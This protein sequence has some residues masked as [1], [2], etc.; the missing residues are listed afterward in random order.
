MVFFHQSESRNC[1]KSVEF[2]MYS[3]NVFIYEPAVFSLFKHQSIQEIKFS[4]GWFCFWFIFSWQKESKFLFSQVRLPP[5][6]TSVA[7][8]FS[9]GMEVEVYSR[10]NDREACGW[11]C[12]DIKVRLNTIIIVFY[13]HHIIG[14]VNKL[15]A[16]VIILD[17]DDQR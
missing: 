6:D 8:I 3:G 15:L 10:S 12:A 11:W 2:I 7:P 16:F 1:D 5:E 17:A 14:I 4:C 13:C 9:E